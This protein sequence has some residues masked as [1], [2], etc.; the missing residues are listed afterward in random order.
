MGL[1]VVVL[2]PLAAIGC[3]GDDDSEPSGS[4]SPEPVLTRIVEGDETPQISPIGPTVTVEAE[5][6]ATPEIIVIGPSGDSP[7]ETTV[8]A[9]GETV[10]MGIG[11]YCWTTMCVDKIGPITRGTLVIASGDEVLVRIPDGAP[12]LR[13]VSIIAFPAAEPQA[14]DNGETAW[15]PDYDIGVTLTSERD[16]EEIRIGATLAPGTYVLSVGMFFESGDVQ[17]GVV[18]EVE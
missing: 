10:G 17:Y 5:P 12:A 7:P 1:A 8:S 15:R 6:S 9:G 11:T 16:D 13:E 14:L 18:L 3:S 4:S 2:L